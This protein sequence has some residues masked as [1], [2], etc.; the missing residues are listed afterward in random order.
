MSLGLAMTAPQD[1]APYSVLPSPYW[2]FL[3][4]Q[5][6][7]ILLSMTL[8]PPPPCTGVPS[9]CVFPPSAT[10]QQPPPSIPPEEAPNP[11]TSEQLPILLFC[12]TQNLKASLPRLC[13]SRM[14]FPFVP[15][16]AQ[17]SAFYKEVLA[18]TDQ[19]G[20]PFLAAQRIGRSSEITI[21]P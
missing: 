15:I 8:L 14:E 18:P 11:F 19:F 2:D 1:P 12:Y 17:L 10:P 13:H 4:L 5:A 16:E 20:F 21:V 6:P 3:G 9:D 7:N